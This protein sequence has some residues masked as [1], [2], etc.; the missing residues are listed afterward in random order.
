VLDVLE[1]WYLSRYGDLDDPDFK[2]NRNFS[3]DFKNVF[4]GIVWQTSLV[5][6]PIFVVIR[7]Q[8]PALI[9]GAIVL[10]TSIYLKVF[11]YNKLPDKD[12]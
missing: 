5:A 6:L 10:I 2:P 11:W 3:R 12:S 7:K 9:S 1:S 4:V 8:V